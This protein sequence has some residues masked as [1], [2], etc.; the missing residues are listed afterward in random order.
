MYALRNYTMYLYVTA[1]LRIVVIVAV[2]FTSHTH[3]YEAL[4]DL[5]DFLIFHMI[6]YKQFHMFKN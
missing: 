4:K 1:V 3:M 5:G 2:S 6:K